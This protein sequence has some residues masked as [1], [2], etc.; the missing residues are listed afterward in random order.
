[1]VRLAVG[2]RK[3]GKHWMLY[4]EDL[5]KGACVCDGCAELD[6]LR[7][8]SKCCHECRLWVAYSKENK[9]LRVHCNRCDRLV[10]D[11]AVASNWK[12]FGKGNAK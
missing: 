4:S 1:M 9:A 3:K 8:V 2:K 6:E 5:D 11:V 10:I 12:V 7:V